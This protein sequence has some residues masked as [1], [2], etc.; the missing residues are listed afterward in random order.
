MK[1][2]F[3]VD[4]ISTIP[5]DLIFGSFQANINFKFRIFSLLKMIRIV[6][7]TKVIA[8]LDATDSVKLSLKLFKLI[9]YLITYIHL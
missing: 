6:R 1:K 5:F 3:A 2:R 4:L 7:F 8:Y 9:F